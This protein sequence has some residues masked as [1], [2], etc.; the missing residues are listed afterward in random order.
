LVVLAL[1]VAACGESVQH[2]APS[3]QPGAV[4]PER[5]IVP[6]VS[7]GGSPTV[8]TSAPRSPQP[9]AERFRRR[10]DAACRRA[11]E[12]ARVS[13]GS[14]TTRRRTEMRR[15]RRYLTRLHERLAT[16]EAPAGRLERLLSDYLDALEAQI[17]LDR[18]IAL[19]A[20]AE[21]EHSVEVGMRQN[22]FNRNDRNAVVA[23]V[24][25]SDC[26]LAPAPR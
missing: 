18:R 7:S 3:E 1:T 11:G 9:E 15:E 16:V 19:A 21:D 4:R 20:Q 23:K 22:V 10:M 17:A 24:G 13:K 8:A 14:D 5:T 2:A 25:L 6:P 12:R 26:L